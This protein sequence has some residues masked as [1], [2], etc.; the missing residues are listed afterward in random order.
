MELYLITITIFFI[1]MLLIWLYL[2]RFL[3]WHKRQTRVSLGGPAHVSDMET[4]SA[5]S[6]GGI[7]EVDALDETSV[8]PRVVETSAR[9]VETLAIAKN[10]FFTGEFSTSLGWF[11]H[12]RYT[13][14]DMPIVDV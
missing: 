9:V 14:N 2:V 6:W 7:A 12:S 11:K 13:Y 8:P 5:I 4:G 3:V 1:V 10:S